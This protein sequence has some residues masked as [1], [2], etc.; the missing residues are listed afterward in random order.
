VRINGRPIDPARTYS[1]AA[2]EGIA[3]M[4]PVLGVTVSNLQVL[5]T[6]EYHALRDYVSALRVVTYGVGVAGRVQDVAAECR[7]GRR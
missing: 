4:L 1:V 6:L 7:R 5:P 3:I 2:N